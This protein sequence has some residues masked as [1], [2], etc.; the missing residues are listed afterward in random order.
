MGTRCRAAVL[1]R[2]GHV[3]GKR[4]RRPKMVGLLWF[5]KKANLNRTL[6]VT[7]CCSYHLGAKQPTFEPHCHFASMNPDPL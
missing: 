1:Q 5:S 7:V 6:V 4:E 3:G 2:F